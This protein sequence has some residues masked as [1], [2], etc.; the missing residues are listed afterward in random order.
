VSTIFPF[1]NKGFLMTGCGS[2]PGR[3]HNKNGSAGF[4]R[5][6]A[7]PFPHIYTI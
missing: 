6:P 2:H 1:K 5:L 3:E 7:L 4:I